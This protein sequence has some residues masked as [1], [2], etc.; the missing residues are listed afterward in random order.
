M[1]A[2]INKKITKVYSTQFAV[3]TECEKNYKNKVLQF[4]NSL[5]TLLGI[6]YG[7]FFIGTKDSIIDVF[8]SGTSMFTCIF[9]IGILAYVA[10]TNLFDNDDLY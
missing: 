8:K 5:G 10:L 2:K 1:V 9:C 6:G 3:V 7:W 4:Y